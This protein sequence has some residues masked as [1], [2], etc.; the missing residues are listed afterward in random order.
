[1]RASDQK[2]KR[3]CCLRKGVTER[4]TKDRSLGSGGRGKYWKKTD[5]LEL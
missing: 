2:R 3:E 1:L 5:L 4:K